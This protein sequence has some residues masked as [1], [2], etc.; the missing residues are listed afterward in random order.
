[1]IDHSLTSL[2]L[3]NR[4]LS[5]TIYS[6]G[7]VALSATAVG[8]ARSVGS[9]ITD[10][11]KAGMEVVVAGFANPANNGVGVISSVAADG[12]S[13]LVSMFVVTYPSGVQTV[14]RPATVV[15]AELGGRTIAA[16]LPSMRAW[17]NADFTPVAGAPY[18]EED[19]IP[20]THTLHGNATGG[21]ADETGLYVLKWYG[22]P[23]ANLATALHKS[24][25]ALRALFT[26]GTVLLAGANAVRMRGEVNGPGAQAGQIIPQGNGWSVVV[27]TIPWRA[28]SVNAVAA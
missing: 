25:D 4:A 13:M 5:L 24:V 7:A 12:L 14:T 26:P 20:A 18:L 3:R 6:T 10:G 19:Y 21:V 8:F 9:F 15:E 1:M 23:G 2:A 27:L 28:Y 16:R 17:E 22:L 11:F